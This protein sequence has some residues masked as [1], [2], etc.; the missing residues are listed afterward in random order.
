MSSPGWQVE[1]YFSL[2]L[3]GLGG[4]PA[5][6]EMENSV[7]NESCGWSSPKMELT[8]INHESFWGVLWKGSCPWLPSTSL[9]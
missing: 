9:L 7:W 6:R 8:P 5:L 1:F 3:E 2:S 4:L